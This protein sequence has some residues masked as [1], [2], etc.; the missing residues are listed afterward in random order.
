MWKSLRELVEVED[1]DFERV[2]RGYQAVTMKLD[3]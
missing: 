1:E 3:G 2:K